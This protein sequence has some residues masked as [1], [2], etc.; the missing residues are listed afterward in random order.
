MLFSTHLWTCGYC[1]LILDELV[2]LWV[3]WGYF[4]EACGLVGEM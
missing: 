2:G 1:G 3:L 4:V